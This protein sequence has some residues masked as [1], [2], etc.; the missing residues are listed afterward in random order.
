MQS[1]GLPA[2]QFERKLISASSSTNESARSVLFGAVI[3]DSPEEAAAFEAR[4]K[5]LPAVAAVDSIGQ[6]IN[7][8]QTGKLA[9]I[10]EIKRE[11]T[12]LRFPEPDPAPVNILKLSQSLYYLSS[13]L[14]AAL[15]DIGSREPELSKQFVSLQQAIKGLRKE[16]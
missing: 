1:E 4:L 11:L 10:G 5:E 3:A 16:M 9:L 13:Y 6:F 8:K 7:E 15:E 2:V 12:A 14:G